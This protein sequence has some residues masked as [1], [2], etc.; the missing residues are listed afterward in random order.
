MAIFGIEQNG[1][2]DTIEGDVRKA[3]GFKWYSDKRTELRD[4]DAA[5]DL[6]R[7]FVGAIDDN[8]TQRG[9]PYRHPST[10]IIG[11]RI[12]ERILRYLATCFREI[13][14]GEDANKNSPCWLNK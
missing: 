7:E 14:S 6:L 9:A 1:I 12:D 10:A 4:P 2:A 8:T 5:R 11:S 13:L 3:L